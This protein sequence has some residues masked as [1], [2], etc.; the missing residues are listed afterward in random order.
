MANPAP[1][2]QPQSP[3]PQESHAP[4][5]LAIDATGGV[6]FPEDILHTT[7]RGLLYRNGE[8]LGEVDYDLMIVPPHRRG[9][10]L[11]S[12]TPPDD[13]PDISGTLTQSPFLGEAIHGG[14]LTL[15]LVDGHRFEFTV[16][17]PETNEILGVTWLHD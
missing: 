1:A 2:S 3:S 15:A 14:R 7:G 10:V 9:T 13:R 4:Q 16:L 6:P 8:R 17:V 11:E 5:P 12:G